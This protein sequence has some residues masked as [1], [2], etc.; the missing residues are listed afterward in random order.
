[1]ESITPNTHQITQLGQD[2]QHLQIKQTI[3][4]YFLTFQKILTK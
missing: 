3:H 4:L 1:M 2:C